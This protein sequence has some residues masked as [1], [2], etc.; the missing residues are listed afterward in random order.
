MDFDRAARCA[1]RAAVKI[2][3]KHV[4]AMATV[5]AIGEDRARVMFDEPQRAITSGQGAVFYDGDVVFGGGWIASASP[6]P[7]T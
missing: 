5:E 7:A 2:R 4:A 3:H 1:V 6:A